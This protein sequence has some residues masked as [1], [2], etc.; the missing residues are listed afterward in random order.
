MFNWKMGKLMKTGN[1]QKEKCK[2]LTN[3][4]EKC[5]PSVS[6]KEI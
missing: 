2:E 3:V 6:I 5:S 4:V 1:L